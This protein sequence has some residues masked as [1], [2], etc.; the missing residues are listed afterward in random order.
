[1]LERFGFS[2]CNPVSTP[3][4]PGLCLSPEQGAETP[5]ERTEMSDL[6]YINAV[7]ALMY[8]ATCTR[9]DIVYLGSLL[10]RFS[11]NPGQKHWQAVKHL[12]WYLKQTLDKQLNYS[13]SVSKKLFVI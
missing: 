11:A 2:D 9:P 5:E 1:M 12:F 3:M 4:E 7:G 13:S 10:A 6:P 8:L